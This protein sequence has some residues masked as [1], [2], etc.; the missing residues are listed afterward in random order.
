MEFYSTNTSKEEVVVIA[1]TSSQ[2][3]YAESLIGGTRQTLLHCL[4]VLVP[5]DGGVQ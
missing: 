2:H 3:V 1:A 4:L 5:A